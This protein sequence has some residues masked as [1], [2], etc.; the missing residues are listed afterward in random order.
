MPA[1]D[2]SFHITRTTKLGYTQWTPPFHRQNASTLSSANPISAFVIC[3]IAI[4]TGGKHPRAATPVFLFFFSLHIPRDFKTAVVLWC[5]CNLHDLMYQYRPTSGRQACF[6]KPL[7]RWTL[8]QHPVND[9]YGKV[10]ARSTCSAEIERMICALQDR[11]CK[12]HM[13]WLVQ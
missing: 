8:K 6:P 10:L 3:D 11:Q 13:W 12:L 5:I 9:C 2:A 1:T 4:H 7:G